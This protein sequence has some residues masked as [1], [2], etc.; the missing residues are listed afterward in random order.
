MVFKEKTEL[1]SVNLINNGKIPGLPDDMCVELP[2]IVDENGVYGKQME[3]LPDAI[4]EMIR[5]QGII[6]KLITEAY[7]EQSRYKL[8]QAA[9]LDPTCTSYNS[10]VAMINEMCE[11]QKEILPVMYW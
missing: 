5:I 10:S 7:T 9:L 8:L 2:A 4:T 6:H 1:L 11:R 3:P